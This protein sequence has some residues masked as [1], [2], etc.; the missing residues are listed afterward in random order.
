MKVTVQKWVN[1]CKSLKLGNKDYASKYKNDQ[2]YWF[3]KPS[4]TKKVKLSVKA[5]KGWTLKS[6]TYN[7]GSSYAYKKIKNNSTIKLSS[8]KNSSFSILFCNKKT[9][10]LVHISLF[11]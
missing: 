1:P 10:E 3:S 9:R 6:I 7:D 2:Y 11:N 8:S 5:N 4:K